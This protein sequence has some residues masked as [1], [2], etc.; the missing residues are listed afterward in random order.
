[1]L[2]I[3][4]IGETKRAFKHRLK[5]HLADINKQKGIIIPSIIEIINMNPDLQ[6]HKHASIGPA[7]GQCYILN[8]PDA[9]KTFWPGIGPVSYA[10][11]RDI[12]PMPALRY[13]P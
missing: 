4:N 10:Q 7:P 5:A 3:E 8:R 13:M 12:G 6:P 2:Y 11:R 9:G 1:M